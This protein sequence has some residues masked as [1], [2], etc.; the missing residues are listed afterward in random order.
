MNDLVPNFDSEA[1]AK[2]AKDKYGI[3]GDVSSLVSFEDQNARIKAP[4]CSYVM[5]IANKRFDENLLHMQTDTIAHIN[6]VAPDLN[7]SR[8]IPSNDGKTISKVDGYCVRL[9]TYLDGEILIN[10]KRSPA[11]YRD[12]GRFMGKFSNALAGY[13][14]PHS[15]KHGDYWNLDNILMCKEHLGD[16]IED[17]ARARI[18]RFYQTYEE[19]VLPKLDRLRKSIVHHDANEQNILVEPDVPD[20]VSGLIDFGEIQYSS[21][22]NELAVCIAYCLLEEEDIQTATDEMIKGYTDEFPL[23]DIEKEVLPD[24]IPM[25][26]VQSII[27]SSNAAKAAPDNEYI[28][29]V[30]KPGKELLRKF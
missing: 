22:I 25:R 21:H 23:E 10:V 19:K 13:S 12:I 8:V 7:I 4:T 29:I 5:K 27:M 14:H 26:M 15:V 16:V 17:E 1:I 6:E 2:I 11:L 28:T 18:E 24:L 20:K 30:Q 3:A 9:F